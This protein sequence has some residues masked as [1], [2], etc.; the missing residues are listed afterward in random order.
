LGLLG[1]NGAG[2]T[3]LVSIVAGL[4]RADAGRVLVGGIDV[5]C[6]PAGARGRIGSP[7][8]HG[9]LSALT[10]RDNLRFFGGLAGLRGHELRR[11]IDETASAL[12]LDALMTRRALE[13]SGVSVAAST[14]R[15]RWCTVRSSC[16][17]MSR[18]P[19][20]RSDARCD[21]ALVRGSPTRAR[22]SCTRRTT[23][24]RSRAARRHRVH[25][26]RAHR[27]AGALA[28]LVRRYGSS[29]LELTF[30]G[31]VPP[32]A[33]PG[34]VVTDA[35]VMIPTDDPTALAATL[36]AQLGQ[37]ARELRGIEIVRPSLD[38]CSSP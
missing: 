35:S 11:A 34:A 33:S 30:D 4:R 23:S 7:A 17:S 1:P 26:S 21:L 22:P 12:M 3:T 2:K 10:V 32:R 20:R 38:R 29:A 9:R 37:R 14:P 6:S 8:G 5:T 19:A 15:S 28:D 36:L 31:E 18:Q 27:R 13:L 25:R 16:C 24:T